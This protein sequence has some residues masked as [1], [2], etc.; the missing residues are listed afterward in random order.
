[1]KKKILLTLSIFSLITLSNTSIESNQ[2]RI[3][4]ID[5][6]VKDN[7]SRINTNK[8]KITTAQKSEADAKKEIANLNNLIN[9][10]QSE[11]NIIEGEYIELLKSIGKST[12]EINSSIQKIE[13]STKKINVG[14]EEY[15]NK[16]KVWNKVLNAK[17]YQRNINTA[18]E[19]KK[20]SDL[21]KILGQEDNK[22]KSIESYKSQVE[23]HKKEEEK[24]KVKKETQ[25]REVEK[26]KKELEGKRNELRNAKASKDQAVRN[27]Q[28]IQSKLKSEN[29]TI[30]KNNANLI[31][32]KKRL[33][34]Q[35]NAIIAAAKKREEEARKKAA[36]E[37]A[38]NKSSNNQNGNGSKTTTPTTPAV[39]VEQP[40]GTGHFIMPISGSI[41]VGYGQEKTPGITSKGIEIRG[42]LGQSVKASD[43]GLVLYSGSLKG[44]GAVIMIDHGNFIT[45]Y[46]NLSSVKVANGAKVT[47]GQ[48]IG[49]LGRD[50]VTKEPNLYFEVR[51]GVNYVNPANYL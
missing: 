49:T 31:A 15:K 17:V 1:M 51:K 36:A 11:Y 3:T 30:E 14:K 37:A 43:S 6:Q 25:A 23:V 33:N 2:K 16:I 13:E 35:I 19:S 47:K 42:S 24:L 22:I 27:L 32:E 41:V 18:E 34:Q 4:Q 45:V 44:L 40:K 29:V 9:K 26:K 50:S 12:Q 39:V 28:A 46:G 10:L 20:Q 48:V 8:N 38:K 5:K 21:I 7:T